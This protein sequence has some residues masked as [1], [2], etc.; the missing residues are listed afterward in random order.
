MLLNLL[1]KDE[2]KSIR[3]ILDS[4]PQRAGSQL[5][6]ITVEHASNLVRYAGLG[7]V[8]SSQGYQTQIVEQV[9]AVIGDRS[10]LLTFY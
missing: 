1:S 9:K 7:I 10:P 4:N 8:V 3:V 6:G 2:L 5:G